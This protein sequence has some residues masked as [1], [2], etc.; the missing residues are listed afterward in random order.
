LTFQADDN[1]VEKLLAGLLGR[2][3]CRLA[4][5]GYLKPF[6]HNIF[7]LKSIEGDASPGLR[8]VYRSDRLTFDQAKASCEQMGARLAVAN[9]AAEAQLLGNLARYIRIFVMCFYSVKNRLRDKK[10]TTTL[11]LIYFL[12][13]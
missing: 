13:S 12:I 8:H 2:F 5:S 11:W 9:S 1:D 6:F 7:T 3:Q 4:S 10:I